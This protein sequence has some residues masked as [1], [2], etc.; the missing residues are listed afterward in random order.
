M[1]LIASVMFV[2]VRFDASSK[3]FAI[4]LPAISS[5]LGERIH[6]IVQYTTNEWD[7]M[8]W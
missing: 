4:L 6:I 3:P 1:P 2:G 8:K 5:F 7:P